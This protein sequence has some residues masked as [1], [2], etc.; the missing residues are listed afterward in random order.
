[1]IYAVGEFFWSSI[2][3]ED[4]PSSLHHPKVG[5]TVVADNTYPCCFP[6]Y[7][8]SHSQGINCASIES[9]QD[10]SEF[11]NGASSSST[12]LSSS[13]LLLT[14]SVLRKT[15]N[16]VAQIH[17]GLPCRSATSFKGILHP[18]HRNYSPEQ[19]QAPNCIPSDSLASHKKVRPVRCSTKLHKRN[20]DI[21]CLCHLYNK[22]NIRREL[23]VCVKTYFNDYRKNEEETWKEPS[24]C[25]SAGKPSTH[26]LISLFTRQIGTYV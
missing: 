23:P 1:M 16:P 11:S 4:L 3:F 15:A 17:G 12:S 13:P 7:I 24:L 25:P 19:S 14:S 8:L 20:D 26:Q 2:K 18:A 21:D 5:T 22:I 9:P 6:C 10:S